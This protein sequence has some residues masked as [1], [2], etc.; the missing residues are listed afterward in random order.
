MTD[1]LENREKKRKKQC[2]TVPDQGNWT[3]KKTNISVRVSSKKNKTQYAMID[4]TNK[5]IM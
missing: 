1:K 2:D 3:E 5:Q 4:V